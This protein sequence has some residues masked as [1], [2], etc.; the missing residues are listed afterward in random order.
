MS[1]PGDAR[2]D[3]WIL[4]EMARRLGL[5]W[6]YA[7]PSDVWDEVRSLW[8]AVRKIGWDR[9]ERDGWCQYPWVSEDGP[10]EDMLFGERCEPMG[11][12]EATDESY[13]YILITGRM[14]ETL[15]YWRHD[16]PQPRP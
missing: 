4:Q 5:K 16:A 3:I 8:P 12:A 1:I 6:P 9:F 11:P 15:A 14:L 10:G 2:Q 13:P 7:H